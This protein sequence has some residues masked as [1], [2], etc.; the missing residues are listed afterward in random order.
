V[1]PVTARGQIPHLSTSGG[2]L[3]NINFNI[4]IM[5]GARFQLNR[6]VSGVFWF[7]AMYMELLNIF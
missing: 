2:Q 3:G 6:M 7:I 5:K 1:V 4:K